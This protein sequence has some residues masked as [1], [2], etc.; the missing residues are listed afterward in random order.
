MKLTR[1]FQEIVCSTLSVVVICLLFSLALWFG[2]SEGL[3][4]G[5]YYFNH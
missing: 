5:Q 1:Y 4:A 2:F 3:A